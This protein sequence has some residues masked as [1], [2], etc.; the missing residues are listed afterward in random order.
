MIE[1]R[2]EEDAYGV[3]EDTVCEELRMPESPTHSIDGSI[4]PNPWQY[5][6]EPKVKIFSEHKVKFHLFG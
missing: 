2:G 6:V 4:R 3:P 1:I 5:K